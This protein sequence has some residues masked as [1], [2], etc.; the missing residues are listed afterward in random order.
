MLNT[1]VSIYD[2]FFSDEE[3]F[4]GFL[5]GS[6]GATVSGVV[7]SDSFSIED[8]TQQHS[9]GVQSSYY[10]RPETEKEKVHE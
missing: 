6:G 3:S 7:A 1:C 5:S 4:Q 10:E 8:E 9:G 2:C